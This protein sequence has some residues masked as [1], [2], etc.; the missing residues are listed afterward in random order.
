MLLPAEAHLNIDV[1]VLVKI[2]KNDLEGLGFL[3]C[4]AK[5]NQGE[6]T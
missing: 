2:T 3:S 1:N 5:F 6:I 4:L